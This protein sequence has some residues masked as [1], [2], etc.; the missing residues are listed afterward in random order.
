VEDE[1]WADVMNLSPARTLS[2]SRLF[3][4]LAAMNPLSLGWHGGYHQVAAYHMED[5]MPDAPQAAG[6]LLKLYELRT[7]AALR[8][9]RSWFAFEFHPS[10]TRDVLSTWLGPGHESAP[11]RMVTTYWEMAASLVVQNAIPPEMFNAA[12]TEHIALFAKLRPFLTEIRATTKYP[13]Y[14]SNVER[15]VSALPD[16]EERIAIFER[17]MIRQ[18]GLAAD[19]KQRPSYASAGGDG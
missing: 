8:Q 11:Y 18:R 4:T 10:S 16:P 2:K 6:L 9:A 13:D 17:Y 3:P 7:E 5:T 1:H 19:G 14:L 12:N 15:V